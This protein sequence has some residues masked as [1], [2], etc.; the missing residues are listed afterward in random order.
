LLLRNGSPKQTLVLP[1]ELNAAFAEESA[2]VGWILA[3]DYNPGAGWEIEEISQG[4]AVMF[5][6][7]NTPHE[8]SESPEMVG[9]FT[10]L[11]AN[12]RCYAGTR[13]D[14]VEA[15]DKI[16]DLIGVNRNAAL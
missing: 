12:A 15:A 11:A 7:R 2:S 13:G 4:E 14:V 8:M 3:V 9:F 16:L 6:L 1:G 10:R 5:L